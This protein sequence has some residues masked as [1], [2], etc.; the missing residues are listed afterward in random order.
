MRLSVPSFAVLLVAALFLAGAVARAQVVRRWEAASD[1]LVRTGD[2]AMRGLTAKDF[3]RLTRLADNVY[4]YEDLANPIGSG[5]A[6]TTNSLIVVT[7]DGVAVVDAQATDAQTKTLVE[8]IGRLSRQPIRYV[9][10][11]ADHADHIGGNS[12]F[13]S[14]VTFISSPASKVAIE[15]FNVA[16]GRGGIRHPIPVPE[17]TVADKRNLT[18]GGEELQILNLGRAHTGGD[19]EVFL[20]RE[21]IMWMSEVFF[22]RIY[23]SVGGGFTAFPSEWI[24]TIKNAEAMHAGVYVPNH[25]FLDPPEV[26]NEEIVNFRHAIEI[27]VFEAKRLHATGAPLETAYR[28]INLGEFQYW[29]RAA[30]N[31]P[32]CVRKVYAEAEGRER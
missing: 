27:V 15:R 9:I 8:T 24:A 21:N 31:M 5:A 25:G 11:G 12:A 13:P 28:N 23:P 16:A 6:F 7:T 14:G 2:V 1:R 20:P 3:P 4:G 30:N 29:Y 18:L 19:L 10:I 17:E 26:L 22:N 32:D